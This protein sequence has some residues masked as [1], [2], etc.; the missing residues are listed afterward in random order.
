VTEGTQAADPNGGLR[1]VRTETNHSGPTA[2]RGLREV[3]RT[4]RLAMRLTQ[5]GLSERSGVSVR[6]IRN[7]E[8]GVITHPREST[9]ELLLEALNVGTSRSGPAHCQRLPRPDGQNRLVGRDRDLEHVDRA[10]RQSRLVVLTGPGGVGKTRLAAEVGDRMLDAFQYGV[11]FAQV[12][13]LAPDQPGEPSEVL[14]RAEIEASLIKRVPD[15]SA[16][17]VQASCSESWS[18]QAGLLLIV[19]NAEHVVSSAAKV[20]R[21]VLADLPGLH[22]LLTSRRPLP[23]TFAQHWEVEPL[24]CDPSLDQPGPSPAIELFL[25]RV[26]ASCPT[27]DLSGGMHAVARLCHR[28]DG[29]PRALELAAARIRS[30][31]LETM[32]AEESISRFLGGMDLNGLPH[33]GSLHESVRWS[34]DLLTDSERAVLRRLARFSGHFTFQEARAA[35]ADVGVPIGDTLAALVDSSLMKVTRGVNYRYRLSNLVREYLDG[36]GL[37]LPGTARPA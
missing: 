22:V 31:P 19:D 25:Q 33:Q 27:L 10:V 21:S 6:T 13:T 12:G 2:P 3:L 9:S 29:L 34:Y 15:L 14:V 8:A 23:V 28:L 17:T 11:S 30:V 7:L 36:A 32:L 5:E 1:L 20:L 4:G 18:A 16:L 26:D 35:T 37:S 24:A